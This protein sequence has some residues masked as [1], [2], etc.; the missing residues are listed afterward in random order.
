MKKF[1]LLLVAPVLLSGCSTITNLTPAQYSRNPSGMYAV[2]ASWSTKRRAVLEE[3]IQPQV[4]IGNESFPM[5]RVPLVRDRWETVV[6][7]PPGQNALRYHFKFDY[8]VNSIPVAHDDS[9]LS[10]EYTLQVVDAA[11]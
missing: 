2:E 8:K 5:R 9:K 1:L 7:I 11:K 3:T 10:P 6:Q 4:M